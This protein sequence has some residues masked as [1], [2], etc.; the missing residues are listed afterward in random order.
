MR[1]KFALKNFYI[2]FQRPFPKRWMAE[3]NFSVHFCKNGDK[4]VV[5]FFKKGNGNRELTKI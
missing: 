1:K 5:R 4:N 3:K 2:K